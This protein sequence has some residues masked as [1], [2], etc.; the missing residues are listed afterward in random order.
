M[1]SLFFGVASTDPATLVG[2][3]ILLMTVA[4]LACYVRLAGQRVSIPQWR[5]GTSKLAGYE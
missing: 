2:V 3:V 4:L 1:K 5:Y